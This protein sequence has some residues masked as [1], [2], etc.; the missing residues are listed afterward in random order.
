MPVWKLRDLP[1]A[2]GR[3]RPVASWWARRPLV[4]P[5]WRD[6]DRPLWREGRELPRGLNSFYEHS[7]GG[8]LGVYI[9]DPQVDLA[10]VLAHVLD[11]NKSPHL[12]GA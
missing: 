6:A 11:F 5:A 2:D 12:S 7:G 10:V 8:Q 4:V 3:R 1:S 9:G